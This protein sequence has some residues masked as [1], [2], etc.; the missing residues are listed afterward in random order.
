MTVKEAIDILSKAKSD[1]ILYKYEGGEICCDVKVT[2]I[3]IG[4]CEY[5][6]SILYGGAVS[7]R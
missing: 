3:L 2:K 7:I 1:A 4:P 5:K 6:D